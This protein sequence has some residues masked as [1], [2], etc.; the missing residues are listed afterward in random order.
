MESDNHSETSLQSDDPRMQRL[1][2]I[3]A[4]MEEIHAKLEYLRL[5][6]RLGQTVR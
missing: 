2:E 3:K 4:Q 5:M 1:L 6:L